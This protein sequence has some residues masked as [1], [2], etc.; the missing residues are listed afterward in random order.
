MSQVPKTV[1]KRWII[2]AASTTEP[3]KINRSA[4]TAL[5]DAAEKYAIILAKK[6]IVM[7]H[8]AGRKTVR[9]EDVKLAAT[10]T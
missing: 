9:E 6:A 4:V 1:S 7:A 3:I 5:G 8:H 2:A 10:T